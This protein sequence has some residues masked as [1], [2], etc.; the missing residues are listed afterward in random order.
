MRRPA[1]PR[2]VVLRVGAVIV[3][4][5]TAA[6]VASD[7]AAL[8][9]RAKEFGEPR[10]AVVARRDLLVGTRITSG[11]VTTRTIYSSQLPPEV[12][13]DKRAAVGRVVTV[14]LLRDGFV[15]RGNVAARHRTGLDGA[16][17]NGM[18]AL[19]IVVADAVQPRVGASVDVL[20]SFE[21][22]SFPTG[23]AESL[24]GL[25]SL[26]TGSATVIAEGVL[27]LGVNAASSAT[28]GGAARGV[29][30]LV[31]PRQARDLVFAM[32]HGVI[33]ISLVPPEDTNSP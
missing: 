15:A 6:L 31:T 10:Q 17:P 20:A 13:D 16:I 11:D 9:R 2:A 28:T 18:R 22:G 19:R 27:V 4:V 3:V 24:E 32:T 21:G 33:T 29:T 23:D 5:V 30:L 26:S 14:P 1:P 12:F 8:H 7:L 25:D